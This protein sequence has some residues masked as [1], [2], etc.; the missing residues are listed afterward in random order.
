[1]LKSSRHCNSMHNVN[2]FDWLVSGNYAICVFKLQTLNLVKWSVIAITLHGSKH[3]WFIEK[4]QMTLTVYM[5]LMVRRLSSSPAGPHVPDNSG[6]ALLAGWAGNCA[7]AS[8]GHDV[9]TCASVLSFIY[10]LMTL[11]SHNNMTSSP[12]HSINPLDIPGIV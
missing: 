5:A 9:M 12:R 3:D 1:M 7:S 8:S 4:D 2:T 6:P 10:S 11:C